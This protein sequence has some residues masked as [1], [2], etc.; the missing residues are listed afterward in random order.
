MACTIILNSSLGIIDETYTGRVT[1]DEFRD[2]VARRVS[3]SKETGVEK[4]L[5]DTSGVTESPVRMMDI[6]SL[7]DSFYAEQGVS[8]RSRMALVLPRTSKE[9]EIAKFFEDACCNRGWTV[10]SFEER[11]DAIDWLQA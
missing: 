9:R 2:A 8:K 7:P 6:Y 11:Q 1:I 4:I 3:L 5:I 10:M